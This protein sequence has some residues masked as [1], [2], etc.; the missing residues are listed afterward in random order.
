MISEI[1]YELPRNSKWTRYSRL[2]TGIGPPILGTKTPFYC[3]PL[4]KRTISGNPQR[5]ALLGGG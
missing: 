5:K 4:V 2:F 3:M 1:R